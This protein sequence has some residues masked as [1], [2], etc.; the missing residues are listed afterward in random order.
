MSEAVL[1]ND[2]RNE[3]QRRWYR[4]I[5]GIERAGLHFSQA[6]FD[7]S[8]ASFD[9]IE[10]RRVRGKIT[11]FG[12]SAFNQ[13]ANSIHL[14]SRQI[15][16]HHDLSGLECGA[17]HLLEV[18]QE[19]IAIGRRLYGHYCLPP[20]HA[21][22]TEKRK[23]PPS[24]V[25]GALVNALSTLRPPI[26]SRRIL[27]YT[28]FVEE[29]KPLRI[30]ADRLRLPLFPSPHSFGC[31]LLTGVQTFLKSEAPYPLARLS[32]F[33]AILAYFRHEKA[34][35]SNPCSEPFPQMAVVK[36]YPLAKA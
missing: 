11:E 10:V 17:K 27:S 2:R 21:N 30:D 33:A 25:S 34:A 31:I 26:E 6:L 22:R 15:V 16:H 7:D 29:H 4:N 1:G 23:R 19:H 13:S 36:T 12:T 9:W 3:G 8:P 28:A 14:V 35:K 24:S 32:Q 18:G 5:E 20:I